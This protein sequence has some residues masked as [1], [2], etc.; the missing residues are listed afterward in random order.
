MPV[1]TNEA[2]TA[3]I[4]SA[5]T[6]A[7]ANL[8][9][10]GVIKLRSANLTDGPVQSWLQSIESITSTAMADAIS[11]VGLAQHYDTHKYYT[12]FGKCCLS[13]WGSVPRQFCPRPPP[14]DRFNLLAFNEFL[15]GKNGKRSN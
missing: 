15:T 9:V 4:E 7:L 10:V 14:S 12:N 5:M 8:Y 11:R 1:W 6:T 13:M 3:L 2:K